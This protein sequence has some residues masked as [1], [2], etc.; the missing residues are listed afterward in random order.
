[1]VARG[2]V[3]QREAKELLS[4]WVKRAGEQRSKLQQQVDE[5]VRHALERVGLSHRAELERLEARIA[6]LE[7]RMAQEHPAQ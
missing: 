4:A 1:L 6:E 3:S 7:R 5:A 2:E